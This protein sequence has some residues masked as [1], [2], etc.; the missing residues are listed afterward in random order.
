MSPDLHTNSPGH[1]W[2]TLYSEK[3][4]LDHKIHLSTSNVISY[5]F[6]YSY[7][8]TDCTLVTLHPDEGHRS[9]R[10]MLVKNNK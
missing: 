7:L 10:N 2:T 1:I 9:D 4:L 6:F 5:I 8:C 3:N